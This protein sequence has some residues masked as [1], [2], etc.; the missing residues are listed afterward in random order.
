MRIAVNA[1]MLTQRKPGG[2]VRYSY[3]TLRRITDRHR[4]HEFLFIVDRPFPRKSA[5]PDNVAVTRIFPSFH[6]VLWYPWFE[7]AVPRILRKFGADLFLSTDGFVSLSTAVPEVVVIHD[8]SFRHNPRDLPLPYRRYFNYYFPRYARK[9]KAI[10]TI[11]EYSKS[12]IVACY[13]APPG[14]ITVTYSGG[15]EGFRPLPEQATA[16]VRRELTGGAP[17]FLSVATLHPRKNLIRLIEAFEK[18]RKESPSEV[19]LVL[20]G[21]RLF[22][23]RD[24]F[25]ALDR[26]SYRKDVIFLGAVPEEK[27]AGIYSGALAL[28]FVSCFEGFGI[29]VLEAMGCDVAVVASN[30]T[31]LPEVC[32]D[33]AYLVDPFSVEAIA[34]A[35]KAV[36]FDETLRRSLVEK[37]RERKTLFSWDR[38]AGLLW[39]AVE[40]ALP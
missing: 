28:M 19:K 3:E 30:R 24:T 7:W 1:R 37:G 38:T 6:P 22:N 23:A 2:I 14:K 34:E 36:C 16:E 27:L 11:S 9:A 40:R 15:S 4:E 25:R 39:E 18:F 32:G 31:A 10:A 29:P 21:P 8:L 12:D 35:M 17:Y 33:A 20:A 26:M 5:F 13:G